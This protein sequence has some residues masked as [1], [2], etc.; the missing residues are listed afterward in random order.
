MLLVDFFFLFGLI[1]IAKE[2]IVEQYE[3]GNN[4]HTQ[5]NFKKTQNKRNENEDGDG[6][7]RKRK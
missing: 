4:T 5:D 3:E 7:E 1:E 2:K 6:G